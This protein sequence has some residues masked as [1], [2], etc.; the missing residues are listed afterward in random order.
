LIQWFIPNPYLVKGRKFD[1]RVF[2]TIVSLDPFI[3]LYHDGFVK[4]AF[5]EWD[6]DSS[7]WNTLIASLTA[8]QEHQKGSG[9]SNLEVLAEV[10][11]SLG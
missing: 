6:A 11:W 1:F 3:V 2:L 9:M 8:T 7:D 5:E 4:I 10:K